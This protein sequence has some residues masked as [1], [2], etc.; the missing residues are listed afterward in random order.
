MA[1]RVASLLSPVKS[2]LSIDLMLLEYRLLRDTGDLSTSARKSIVKTD[3]VVKLLSPAKSPLSI[4]EIR[5]MDKC[6]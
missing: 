2:P 6:L 5:L 1:D 3:N 4:D